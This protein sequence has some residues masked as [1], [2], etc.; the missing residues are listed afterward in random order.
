VMWFWKMQRQ[1]NDTNIFSVTKLTHRIRLRAA[2]DSDVCWS[3]FFRF[4]VCRRTDVFQSAT[5]AE[6]A[7]LWLS[8]SV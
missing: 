1:Q 8:L 5:A 6:V 2:S 7:E 3:V 4:F